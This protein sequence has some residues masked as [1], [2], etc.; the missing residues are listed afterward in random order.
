M[1]LIGGVIGLCGAGKGGSHRQSGQ[2]G[3][4]PGQFT[5]NPSS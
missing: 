5:H 4:G 3:G 1:A 2:C